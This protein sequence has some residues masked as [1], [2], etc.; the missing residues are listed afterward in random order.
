MCSTYSRA[1]EISQTF[2]HIICRCSYYLQRQE[3]AEATKARDLLTAKTGSV[4]FVVQSIFC[5]QYAILHRWTELRDALELLDTAEIPTTGLRFWF[6]RRVLFECRAANKED[7]FDLT[8]S[9]LTKWGAP[10]FDVP[11]D[12][13]KAKASIG[14][15]VDRISSTIDFENSE[16]EMFEI[17]S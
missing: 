2:S 12:P 1:A 8:R 17:M 16:T 7:M 9:F 4:D 5:V 14:T 6:G 13:V 10:E 11:L 15:L 3:F